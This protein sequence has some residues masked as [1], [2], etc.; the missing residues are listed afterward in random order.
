MAP[1]RSLADIDHWVYL[2]HHPDEFNGLPDLHVHSIIPAVKG[3]WNWD[4]SV[5]SPCLVTIRITNRG[6]DMSPL[7]EPFVVA[8]QWND[9]ILD[10]E[11]VS[12]SLAQGGIY[13]FNRTISKLPAEG[14]NFRVDIDTTNLITEYSKTNNHNDIFL[15]QFL[16]IT[17]GKPYVHNILP[18]LVVVDV[19]FHPPIPQVNTPF[20][21]IIKYRNN[22]KGTATA[23]LMFIWMGDDSGGSQVG[24]IETPFLLG[25]ETKNVN[26]TWSVSALG[27][28]SM[29]FICDAINKVPQL[30][31]T[32]DQTYA[33]LFVASSTRPLANWNHTRYV[34]E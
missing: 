34:C 26:F 13:E 12:Q 8:C 18:D 32:N 33:R 31:R 22:G 6:L 2:N 15:D 16:N 7:S 17:A 3:P 25:G 19:I 5:G 9:V 14:T 1:S 30:N 20:Q 24:N 11:F 23:T 10:S 21:S 29:G 27:S 28:Y 4:C